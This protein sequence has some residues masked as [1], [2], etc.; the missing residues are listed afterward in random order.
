[1][2]VGRLRDTKTDLLVGSDNN[3]GNT[4]PFGDNEKKLVFGRFFY[5]QSDNTGSVQIDEFLAFDFPLTAAQVAS[6][7]SSYQ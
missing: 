6:I 4:S 1:M 7:Y 5:R 3:P 2:Q